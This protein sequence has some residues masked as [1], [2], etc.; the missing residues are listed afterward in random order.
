MEANTQQ[1]GLYLENQIKPFLAG[2]I[3]Q[4]FQTGVAGSTSLFPTGAWNRAPGFAPAGGPN[5]EMGDHHPP[6]W[7]SGKGG[8]LAGKTAVP[9]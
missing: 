1:A 6:C 3:R 9:R 4:C 5:S 8:L 7:G 2:H